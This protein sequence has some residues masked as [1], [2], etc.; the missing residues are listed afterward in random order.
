[1]FRVLGN[2]Y[3]E[4]SNASFEKLIVKEAIGAGICIFHWWLLDKEFVLCGQALDG[5]KY[6]DLFSQGISIMTTN[7]PDTEKMN[8][9]I[10][11]SVIG[12][13]EFCSEAFEE[14]FKNIGGL[15]KF[16]KKSIHLGLA[17]HF[18]LGCAMAL[19]HHNSN[20]PFYAH[21]KKAPESFVVGMKAPGEYGSDLLETLIKAAMGAG[22]VSEKYL[23]K[24]PLSEYDKVC[25][26]NSLTYW[27]YTGK[28]KW[29]NSS[30]MRTAAFDVFGMGAF[31]AK[32]MLKE[33][34]TQQLML[35]ALKERL[36]AGS[37]M[38]LFDEIFGTDYCYQKLRED[39]IN[40]FLA[41]L[42]EYGGGIISSQYVLEGMCAIQ[43]LGFIVETNQIMKNRN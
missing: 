11:N 3:S 20:F 15:E 35:N 21:I 34:T 14:L 37:G 1:M 22:L 29:I 25:T 42:E 27:S 26:W 30:L 9:S 19:W 7:R 40:M 5:L 16:T 4:N 6:G 24:S 36:T 10:C 33:T 13:L 32:T 41:S 38:V 17:Y 18:Q 12:F 28:S 43:E 23:V 39:A 8:D 2:N 31:T